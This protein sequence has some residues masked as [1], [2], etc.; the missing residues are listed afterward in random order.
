MTSEVVKIDPFDFILRIL[1]V[2]SIFSL[3]NIVL[4][5]DHKLAITLPIFGFWKILN[6][7]FI[8]F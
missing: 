5:G 2:L 4:R 3:V 1:R 7:N 6:T 8:A